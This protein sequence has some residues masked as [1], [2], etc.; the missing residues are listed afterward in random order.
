MESKDK[1]SLMSHSKYLCKHRR[2]VVSSV[3]ADSGS[4]DRRGWLSFFSFL[5]SSLIFLLLVFF[6][7]SSPLFLWGSSVYEASS[8]NVGSIFAYA[9]KI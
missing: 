2:I 3:A 8:L 9:S 6:P 5:Q 1:Y 7:L 4:E